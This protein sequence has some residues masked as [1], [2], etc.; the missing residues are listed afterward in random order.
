METKTLHLEQRDMHKARR[1]REFLS[2][3]KT[4]YTRVDVDKTLRLMLLSVNKAELHR[5]IFRSSGI[6]KVHR[7]TL[8]L[9]VFFEDKATR[10]LRQRE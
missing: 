1:I 4:E 6:A 10:G 8:E 9:F 5:N 2:T 7:R 3:L